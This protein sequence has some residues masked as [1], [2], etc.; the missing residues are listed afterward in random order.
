MRVSLGNCHWGSNGSAAERLIV[1]ANI[2]TTHVHI[3]ALSWHPS[4]KHFFCKIKKK[5][6]L[7]DDEA[8]LTVNANA[9]ILEENG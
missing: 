4:I 5:K 8:L 7:S 3:R 2:T 1:D 6:K 9:R